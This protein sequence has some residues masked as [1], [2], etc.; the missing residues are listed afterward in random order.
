[1]GDEFAD[2]D[3]VNEASLARLAPPSFNVCHGRPRIKGGVDFDGIEALRVMLEPF[4]GRELF[5][6]E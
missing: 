5:G 4:A 6:I 1:V 2:L 3:G